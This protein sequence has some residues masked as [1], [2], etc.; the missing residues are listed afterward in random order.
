MWLIHM[1][2]ASHLYVWRDS[3][4]C[5]T[6]LVRWCDDVCDV[7]HVT[8][9]SRWRGNVTCSCV[10]RDS[11]VFATLGVT[12]LIHI[13]HMKGWRGDVT[14]SCVWRD[15]PV[16]EIF[17]KDNH[18]F[19]QMTCRVTTHTWRIV[20]VKWIRMQC[21]YSNVMPQCI[22]IQSSVMHSNECIPMYSN[23][24]IP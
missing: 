10:W 12:W 24:G 19:Q 4:M 20:F 17:H 16:C 3:F 11:L 1:C 14:C 9:M 15:S 13:T 21:H 23:E 2:D 7:T 8:H 22:P 5:V 18:S 6:W